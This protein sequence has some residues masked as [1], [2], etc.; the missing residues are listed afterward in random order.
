MLNQRDALFI[1]FFENQ[2]PLR[3]SSI[4]CQMTLYARNIP[5]AVCEA[6]PEDEQLML[7]TCRGP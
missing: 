4:T 2:G 1:Q 3:V 5:N 6:P 7:E